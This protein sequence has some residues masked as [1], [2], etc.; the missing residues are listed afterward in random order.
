MITLPRPT[1]FRTD[2]IIRFTID[3]DYE[4]LRRTVYILDKDVMTPED[5]DVVRRAF[6]LLDK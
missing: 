4:L 3:E 6:C 2:N 1:A 5:E